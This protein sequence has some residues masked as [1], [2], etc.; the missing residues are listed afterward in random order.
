M[1][2]K[3]DG[4]ECDRL[5]KRRGASDLGQTR[6]KKKGCPRFARMA[7]SRKLGCFKMFGSKIARLTLFLLAKLTGAKV[8]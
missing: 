4:E 5:G 7:F 2:G 6:L 3:M 8:K 1:V